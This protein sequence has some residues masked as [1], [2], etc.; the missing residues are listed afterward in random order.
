VFWRFTPSQGIVPARTFEDSVG[1]VW[2]VFE[3][4]RASEAPRGVSAGLEK[5]WLAFVSAAEKRRLAPYPAAWESAPPSELER[6]CASA[7]R[8]NP[9]Q[10]PIRST[11]RQRADARAAAPSRESPRI[12]DAPLNSAVES[13]TDALVR[14]AVRE[15]AHEAR[16]K[17]MPAIAAMV[18]LKTMLAQRFIGADISPATRADAADMRRVRRWFVEAYYFERPA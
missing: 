3:V 4:H 11:D 15:F 17:K 2:E 8:A 14:D 7:R 5:G 13:A 1:I 10:L 16:A 6:L 9:T 12:V 18:G